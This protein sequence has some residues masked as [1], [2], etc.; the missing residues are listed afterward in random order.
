M[1][2]ELAIIE[3]VSKDTYK[4]TISIGSAM[5]QLLQDARRIYIERTHRNITLGYVLSLYIAGDKFVRDIVD[6]VV[7]DIANKVE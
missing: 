7:K 2:N 1:N 5:H 3:A 6:A 4:T